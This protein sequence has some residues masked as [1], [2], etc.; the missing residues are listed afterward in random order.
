MN[1]YVIV[2]LWNTNDKEKILKVAQKIAISQTERHSESQE[3]R[4]KI[5]IKSEL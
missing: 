3:R 5:S 2:K 1:T 4:L